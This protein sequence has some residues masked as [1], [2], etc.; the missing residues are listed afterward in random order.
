MLTVGLV[1]WNGRCNVGD[2]IMTTA[3]MEEIGE[4]YPRVLF[5]IYADKG[6]LDGLPEVGRV[7]AFPFMNKIRR[8]PLLRTIAMRLYFNHRLVSEPS[9]NILIFGGGSIFKDKKILANYLD[10]LSKAK[11]SNRHVRAVAVGVSI[12]PFTSDDAE[13]LAIDILSRLDR[14]VVRDERSYCFIKRRL[15]KKVCDLASDLA[16]TYIARL[17]QGQRLIEKGY[18][19]GRILVSLRA[20]VLMEEQKNLVKKLFQYCRENPEMSLRFIELCGEAGASDDDFARALVHTLDSERVTYDFVTYNEKPADVY[21][22]IAAAEVSVSVRL[23]SAILAVGAGVPV[24]VLA[25]H[26]K[27]YDFAEQAGLPM[28]T[29]MTDPEQTD[30]AHVISAARESLAVRREVVKETITEQA[31][32]NFT[33][34]DGPD[35]SLP[36]DDQAFKIPTN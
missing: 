4:R 14:V 27:I 35:V 6:F 34:L 7:T 13:L 25:Y 33:W 15:P 32:H 31:I 21:A 22:E 10:I 5:K 19:Q 8:L 36:E 30:L 1:G 11:K 24:I 9:L 18:C 23:H 20:G 16:F 2:D 29:I 12:G 26:Q 17:P 3:I 28:E